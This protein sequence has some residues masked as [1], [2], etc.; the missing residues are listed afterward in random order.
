[1]RGKCQRHN[2]IICVLLLSGDPTKETSSS[3][4]TESGRFPFLFPCPSP[5]HLS[6]PIDVPSDTISE[7]LK[8]SNPFPVP[9]N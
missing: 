8:H 2:L 1:M 9:L 5:P 6:R 7:A 3:G 4:V